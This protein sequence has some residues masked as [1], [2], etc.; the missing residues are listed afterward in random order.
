MARPKNEGF[1]LSYW[2]Q[3]LFL[4]GLFGLLLALPYRVRVPLAGWCVAHLIAPVAG[5]K[6]RVRNNL[7]RILPLMPAIQRKVLETQVPDNVGRTLIEIYSGAEFVA[8]VL[9]TPVIGEGFDAILQ[10]RERGQGVIL[11]AGHFGNYD[12]VRAVLAARGHKIGGLYNPMRNPYFNAHYCKT[13]GAISQPM[14]ARGR[15]GLAEMVRFLRSGGMVGMLIDQHMAGGKNLTFFGQV[16][17]TALSA[18]E[19]SLKYNLLLVPINAIRQPDGLSFLIV[20]DK[21]IQHGDP[22]IM[23]QSLNDSLEVLVR[24]HPEQWF[25]IH[26]RWRWP[27]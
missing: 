19:M 8:Q 7:A 4:R 6:K 27:V 20:V 5:Y 9:D 26:R 11:V 10:A 23:T 12:V 17:R 14:F 1:Q 3:N 21:P 25:W 24:A 2:L 13:I 18:A 15:R 16:A 22:A